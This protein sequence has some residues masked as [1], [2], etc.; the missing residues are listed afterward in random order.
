[1]HELR[2]E[3]E[4][5]VEDLIARMTPVDILIIEGFRRHA[6]PKLEVHRPSLG[7]ALMAPGDPQVVAIASD[8][9][10]ADAPVP[11]LDLDDAAAIARFVIGHCGLERNRVHGVA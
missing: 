11:V 3:P 2:D 1:M 8:A 4:P 6:H 9:P 10:L 5:A 7:K